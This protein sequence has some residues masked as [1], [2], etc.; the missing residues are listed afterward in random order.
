M[1]FYKDPENLGWSGNIY[2]KPKEEVVLLV[3]NLK[4]E[5]QIARELEKRGIEKEKQTPK[6]RLRMKQELYHREWLILKP[7]KYELPG[8][9]IP[10]WAGNIGLQEQ[11]QNLNPS[12][13]AMFRKRTRLSDIANKEQLVFLQS[14]GLKVLANENLLLAAADQTAD[15]EFAQETGLLAGHKELIFRANVKDFQHPDE[16]YP[17]FW[18]LIRSEQNGGMLR[19]E[20]DKDTVSAP[21]WVPLMRLYREY[22]RGRNNEQ[23]V[24][25]PAHIPGI[26]KAMSVL[27]DEG[28]QN[29]EAT[30]THLY[31]EFSS[32]I[33]NTDEVCEQTWDEFTQGVAPLR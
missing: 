5:A 14:V 33:K 32:S 17:R 10:W 16:S 4:Q 2:I 28:H 12:V 29:L 9:K 31:E 30:Q 3:R 15:D 22:D 27:I 11:F 6:D 1:R 23:F 20:P 21:A 25:H 19:T 7:S 24:I 8:G 18:Y 26:Y 13:D